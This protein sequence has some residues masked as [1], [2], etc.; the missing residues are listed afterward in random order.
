[1][2]F[3]LATALAGETCFVGEA[4]RG[5]D[6][7]FARLSLDEGQAWLEVPDW[8]WQRRGE[9][10]PEGEGAFS[11]SGALRGDLLLTED[12]GAVLIDE[13]G[14]DIF[15]HPG[16]CEGGSLTLRP[17]RVMR[18]NV[19]Y[20]TKVPE[21][22]QRV[23]EGTVERWFARGD[24]EVLSWVARR[25]FETVLEGHIG[26]AVPE[27]LR[28]IDYAYELVVDRY[29][30]KSGEVE[31][32]VGG[33]LRVWRLATARNGT[34]IARELTTVRG[35]GV[36]VGILSS[37]RDLELAANSLVDE[38]TDDLRAYRELGFNVAIAERSL[39]RV[40]I[41]AGTGDAMR[42]NERFRVLRS[43]EEGQD[44][45]VGTVLVVRSTGDT[46]YAV[47]QGARPWAAP[48]PGDRLVSAGTARVLRAGVLGGG[49]PGGPSG[50]VYMGAEG[51]LHRFS[52]V[53]PFF[54]GGSR[55][56]GG[57]HFGIGLGARTVVYGFTF[58][59]QAEVFLNGQ[60]DANDNAVGGFTSVWELLIPIA[61]RADVHV[62]ARSIS[63]DD[64]FEVQPFD[65]DLVVVAGVTW[66]L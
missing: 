14:A 15:L 45:T 23:V 55:G 13:G 44:R 30:S 17:L 59:W 29:E 64:A 28:G 25:P 58:G 12:G 63:L 26:R 53:F 31:V 18:G 60:T 47:V 43:D 35:T 9:L 42:R 27:Q 20:E 46:S 6:V 21:R 54:L 40:V 61:A 48:A 66:T 41:P 8:D 10:E 56:A 65:E 38:F 11:T 34:L 4:Y 1:M 49:G 52:V 32:K 19:A 2:I 37:H 22:A 36:G 62:Q 16:G 50:G 3:L 24:K 57:L 51:Q 33:Q 7:A 39:D 5:R